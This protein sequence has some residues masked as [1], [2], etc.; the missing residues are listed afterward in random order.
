MASARFYPRTALVLLTALNLLNYIDRSV[1]FAV[2]PLVQAEFHRS[3]AAFGLLTSAF[4]IVYMLAA[5]LVGPLADRFRRKPILVVGA[6]LWSAATMLTAAT[7]S[8]TVL[9]IRHAIVGIGEASFAT[10]SPT[11][12]VDLFPQKK[13]GRILGV[14]Y[15]ALPL[16]TA[17]GYLMGGMLGPRFGWRVPFYLAGAPGLLLTIALAFLPEPERGAQDTLTV[18]PETGTL[19][20]LARNLAFLTASLG[21]AAMTFALGGLQVWM[22]TFLHRMRGYSLERANVIFGGIIAL[23]G[24]AASLAG[25]WL[26]DLLLRRTKA[27]YYLVSATGLALAL[28]VMSVAIYSPGPAMLPAI[29]VGGFLLLLNTAPLNAALIN[30]VAPNIRATAIAVNILTIHLLGDAISPWLIGFIS[31]RKSLEGGL[32][33]AVV[34]I[35]ISSVILFYGMRY[36]PPVRLET[37]GARSASPSH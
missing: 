19:R 12:V 33:S 8:F 34:A 26:G 9:F 17:L 6:L 24:V 16:G 28:P 23:N 35:A 3:D 36:A 32:G 13:R 7:H 37:R 4:F 22:P 25:G 1:L 14:F 30:A 31:D 15:M 20:G 11:W 18:T 2:Q 21:M 27:A 29:F 5:P 10:I